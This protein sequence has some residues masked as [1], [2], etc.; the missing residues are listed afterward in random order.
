MTI[1][2][3]VFSDS[4]R[5]FADEAPTQSAIIISYRL[6]WNIK[7]MLFRLAR[8]PIFC[9]SPDPDL[10]ACEFVTVDLW[11]IDKWTPT[12]SAKTDLTFLY[13]AQHSIIQQF[14]EKSCSMGKVYGISSYSYHWACVTGAQ[15]TIGR[16][17]PV[18]PR[19]VSCVPRI[20]SL[21]ELLTNMKRSIMRCLLENYR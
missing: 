6:F 18:R 12:M 19:F 17:S 13:L 10:L 9:Q 21:S 7:D 14:N 20:T 11:E 4:L 8:R 15:R 3:L 2:P 16:L 1:L 5:I